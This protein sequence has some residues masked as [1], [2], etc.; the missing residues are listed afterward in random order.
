MGGPIYHCSMQ[1]TGPDSP[2]AE[3]LQK[4]YARPGRLRVLMGRGDWHSPGDRDK[5][6]FDE[7]QGCYRL[8]ARNGYCRFRLE[9]EVPLVN[10]V[11]LVE[12]ASPGAVS[13]HADGLAI[14]DASRTPRGGLLFRLAGLYERTVSVEISPIEE[15]SDR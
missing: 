13:I 12:G 11:F 14:R 3:A 2:E 6:G 15:A 8:R 5:D 9:P 1:M 10:P 4:A 7:S